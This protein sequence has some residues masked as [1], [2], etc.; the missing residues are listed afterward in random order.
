MVD[1]VMGMI[2]KNTSFARQ[3]PKHTKHDGEAGFGGCCVLG[4]RSFIICRAVRFGGLSW[5]TYYIKCLCYIDKALRLMG[6]TTGGKIQ[7]TLWWGIVGNEDCIGI[8]KG[9]LTMLVARML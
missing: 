7:Q 8:H 5:Q 2:L 4:E 9:K 3:E 1:Y 6:N